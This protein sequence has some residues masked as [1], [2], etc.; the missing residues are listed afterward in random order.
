LNGWR[1][2]NCCR[3]RWQQEACYCCFFHTINRKIRRYS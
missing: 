3:C 2:D 1:W